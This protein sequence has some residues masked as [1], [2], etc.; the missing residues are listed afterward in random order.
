MS[1]KVKVI[2]EF[3]RTS[4]VR[5]LEIFLDSTIQDSRQIIKVYSSSTGSEYFYFFMMYDDE[6]INVR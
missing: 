6:R 5:Q 1:V 3:D 4:F 2:T